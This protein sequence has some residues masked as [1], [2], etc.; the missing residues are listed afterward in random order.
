MKQTILTAWVSG[1]IA[2]FACAGAV[3]VLTERPVSR[4]YVG[5]PG[6]GSYAGGTVIVNIP[7]GTKVTAVALGCAGD[8][9]RP[10]MPAPDVPTSPT[11]ERVEWQ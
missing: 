4:T 11:L 10:G 2:G 7:S 6:G 1:V 8:T 5:G 9:G 3:F